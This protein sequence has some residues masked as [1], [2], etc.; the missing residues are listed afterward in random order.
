M[1]WSVI[2]INA[3]RAAPSPVANTNCN[4]SAVNE[5]IVSASAG[6]NVSS[7]YTVAARRPSIVT[8]IA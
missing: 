2:G 7:K 3:A 6:R 5:S 1:Y 4:R 8:A